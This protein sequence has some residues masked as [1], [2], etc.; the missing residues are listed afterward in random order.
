M[1]TETRIVKEM[2]DADIDKWIMRSEG[3]GLAIKLEAVFRESPVHT[4]DEFEKVVMAH[5][6]NQVD[7]YALATYIISR[8]ECQPMTLGG[9]TPNVEVVKA[10]P[11]GSWSFNG[12]FIVVESQSSRYNPGT[13]IFVGYY[14]WGVSIDSIKYMYATLPDIKIRPC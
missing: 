8:R 13:I 11:V 12:K 2:I 7:W 5:F 9:R 4:L 14:E 1:N 3:H 10:E 6:R